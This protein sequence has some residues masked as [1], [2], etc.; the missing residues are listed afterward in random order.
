MD[1]IRVT[2]IYILCSQDLSEVKL[3]I[4]T[5]K[6]LHSDMLDEDLITS[7]LKKRTDLD[8]M[9]SQSEETS[10]SSSSFI[11]G[12]AK[13]VTKSSKTLFSNIASLLT[14]QKHFIHYNLV[15]KVVANI[16]GRVVTQNEQFG[17]PKTGEKYQMFRDQLKSVV[18]FVAG[19]GS[20]YEYEG[21][22]KLQEETKV[23]IIYGCDYVFHPLE[24]IQELQTTYAQK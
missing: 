14:D 7:I 15:K 19:G 13:Q 12:L 20:F 16:T 5:L 10:S 3:I 9:L 11:Q 6:Q 8:S 21:M 4:D 18:V 2:I 17:D 22:Q 23:Q 24:F 1:K